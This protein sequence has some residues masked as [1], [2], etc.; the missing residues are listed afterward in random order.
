MKLRFTA[1]AAAVV[2]FINAFSFTVSAENSEGTFALAEAETGTIILESGADTILPCGSLA[3]LMTAL[4]AAEAVEDGRASLDENM[5]ASAHANSL[6]GAE[7][8]L[9]EGEKMTLGDLLKGAIPGNANDAA[10]TI[11]ENLSGSEENFTEQMN[12]K[13]ALL[14]LN[15]THFADSTGLGNSVSTAG[16]MAKLSCELLRFD[17]VKPVFSIYLDYVRNGETQIVNTNR[18]VRTYE[19]CTGLKYSYSEESGYCAAVSAE[20]DGKMF[21]AALLGY[22]DKDKLFA[23]A[24]ELLDHGFSAYSCITPE[25]PEDFPDYIGVK[26][27]VSAKV[28]AA[29]D[30]DIRIVVPNGKIRLLEGY[31]AYPEYVYAPVKAGDKLGELF[32]YLD[33]KLVY[34]GD[35]CAKSNVKAKNQEFSL[36]KLLKY[37]FAF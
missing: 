5:T 10:C 9:T 36:S 25:A 20:R 16:D 22:S 33:G 7:I 29:Y 21:V 28:R 12:S 8:W 19:G 27:G 34:R 4:L 18:L 6:G 3:K 1:A 13:A 26:G 37:I 23:K 30:K 35:I 24:R 31:A 14:G 32:Y 2:M 15:G 17:A 11:A